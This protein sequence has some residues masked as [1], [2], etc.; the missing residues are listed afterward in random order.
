MREYGMIQGAPAWLNVGWLIALIVFLL[1]I[2]FAAVGQLDY[3]L[4]GLIGGAALARLIP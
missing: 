1:C 3:K 4:A 2:I